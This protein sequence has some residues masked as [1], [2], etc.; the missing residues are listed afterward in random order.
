MENSSIDSDAA[1]THTR[2]EAQWNPS[3]ASTYLAPS[4]EQEVENHPYRQSGPALLN[5]QNQNVHSYAPYN[6]DTFNVARSRRKSVSAVSLGAD[7]QN[8]ENDL[9]QSSYKSKRQARGSFSLPFHG[10]RR[11]IQ[12]SGWFP[13]LR[14]GGRRSKYISLLLLVS[15]LIY[16]IILWRRMYEIQIE[17]SIFSKKWVASEID[18]LEPLHGCFSPS[19]ISPKYN[20]TKHLAPRRHMLS[21][22]VSLK[23]GMSCYDFASTIQPFPDAPLEHVYY[24]TYWR[25]DLLPF[26]ERQTATF[27]SFLATQPLSHSTLILWTNGANVLRANPHVAPF[28]KRWGEYIQV[29]EVDLDVLTQGTELASILGSNG[30]QKGIFDERAWVDGD[31]VRLLV[32]WNYGG[33][34]MD[35]DQLLTRDLHPLTEEEWVTQWDCYDKPYFSLNGALMHFQP[36]SPYLCEAFHIMA[37]SPLPKPNTFTWGSHL[38]AKLHRHLIA[39]NKRPFAVLPWCFSDPRNCRLDNR[40][41][42]PFAP[43]P[44]TFAGIPWSSSQDGGHGGKSGREL[45]EEKSSHVYSIHLHNQWSKSFPAGG[46]VERLLDGYKAQVERVE[47]YA[48]AA[49]LVRDGRVVLE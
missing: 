29:R 16:A 27:L 43:D 24:H 28:L 47:R 31:A 10:G 44:P 23:R 39:A 15:A 21:A 17:F 18:S 49:G 37:S 13:S 33:I 9:L 1:S 8:D 35:M 30:G 2:P 5:I 42:D 7:D 11:R 34:W 22:G 48:E 46:W 25:A 40:F 41:P 3:T 4:A 20:L 6:S 14:R 26:G 32:L 45:L 38:Y 19:L 36:F 12:P